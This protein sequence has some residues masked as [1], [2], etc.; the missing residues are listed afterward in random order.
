MSS[1]KTVPGGLV[2]LF[3]GSDGVGKTTQL[4]LAAEELRKQSWQVET[5]RH[6]GG[7]PM[8]EAL[9]SASLS[10]VERLPETD[11]YI[12]AAIMTELI[13]AINS[14]RERGS[15]VLIDRGS[16]SLYAYQVS[17]SGANAELGK[18]F[19]DKAMGG[20]KPEATLLF[21]AD[22]AKA[23]ERAKLVS[24]KADYFESKPL[25]FFE[26]VSQGLNEAAAWYEGVIHIDANQ[27][28]E[29]VQEETLSTIRNVL[30]QK[31]KH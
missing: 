25:E 2:V 16:L 22:I 1:E 30:E 17:G 9:R 28:V 4:Q 18:Q 21:E 26:R 5:F 15:I 7:T 27:S 24:G 10:D 31:T 12:S 19:S 14:A 6:L 8:G 23:L 29:A 11:L 3:E 13:A 20:Y